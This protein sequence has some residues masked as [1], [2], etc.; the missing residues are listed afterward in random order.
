MS[1]AICRIRFELPARGI[2]ARRFLSVPIQADG[3]PLCREGCANGQPRPPVARTSDLRVGDEVYV[4]G[5]W[6]LIV[7]IRIETAELEKED[8]EPFLKLM[9]SKIGLIPDVDDVREPPADAYYS[10]RNLLSVAVRSKK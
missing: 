10:L 3:Q 2:Q 8:E 9:A 1:R 4:A 7:S 6:E 5:Q